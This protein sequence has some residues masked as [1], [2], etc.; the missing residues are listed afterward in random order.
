MEIDGR[1]E[2]LPRAADHVIMFKYIVKNTATKRG[3]TVTFM[4]KPLFG[5]NGSGMHCHQSL[6]RGGK[7][8]FAGDGYGGFLGVGPPYLR[9]FPKHLP[10][11][12]PRISAAPQPLKRAPPRGPAPGKPALSPPDPAPGPPV[13][14]DP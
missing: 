14:M 10:G 2:S 5:D 4:P 8:L 9:G 11:G 6:W 7:N 1:F 3:R 13:P 12:A